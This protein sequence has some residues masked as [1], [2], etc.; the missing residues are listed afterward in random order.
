MSTENE[1]VVEDVGDIGTG[2]F[3]KGI[4]Q[5]D[6]SHAL[7]WDILDSENIKA[8]EG[9]EVEVEEWWTSKTC[10]K[11]VKMYHIDKLWPRD[12]HE[13]H[14]KAFTTRPW[15]CNND[16]FVHHAEEVWQALFGD[17]PRSKGFFNY[18][19]LSMVYSELILKKKV[20]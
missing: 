16:H 8:E 17:C 18:S 5:K 11:Y 20:D 14:T 12:C 2:V 15:M 9:W 6:V 10:K 1:I 19:L 4:K 3:K 7:R 13:S